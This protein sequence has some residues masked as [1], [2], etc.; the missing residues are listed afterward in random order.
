MAI[1][2]RFYA[3]AGAATLGD[4]AEAAG[5]QCLGDSG[6][7]VT[8]V[9]AANTAIAGDVCFFEGHEKDMAGISAQAAGCFI[10]ESQ[11]SALPDGVAALVHADPRRVLFA[12]AAARFHLRT[13]GAQPTVIA[14][15][16]SVHPDAVLGPGVVIGSG[17]AI[18]ARTVIGPNSVVGPG[19]QIG[20]DCRIGA[21]VSIQCALI[22]NHVTASAGV[23]IGEAG[24]GIM[25]GEA[26]AQDIPHFGRAILQDHVSLGANTCVDRGA[27]DDTVIGEYT[28][29]DNFC[30]IAH[31]AQIGRNVIIAAF[32]GVSGSVTIGDG[33]MLGGRAGVADHVRI[34]AGANLAASTG[35]FRDVPDGETWGGTPGKPIRLWMRETA[36][37][38][39]QV[40]P[41][42]KPG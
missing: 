36:W 3:S 30:Q 1:D 25:P 17:A 33:A 20:T 40:A 34:G 2:P 19:V 5:A 41:K 11:A 23:R 24:F 42:K 16:A 37:L 31:N 14:E 13:F 6:A 12:T 4:W 10:T 38:Q 18:G 32:A 39:K 9:G 15:T 27:F 21:T 35:V 28:K 8:G 22:G 26:G 29:I 7:V